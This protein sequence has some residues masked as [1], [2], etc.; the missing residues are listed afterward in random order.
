MN[1]RLIDL[2]LFFC[3][4]LFTAHYEDLN[5]Q[6]F[7]KEWKGVERVQKILTTVYGEASPYT[8][9]MKLISHLIELDQQTR[10]LITDLQ[11]LTTMIDRL[12]T[13]HKD[14]EQAF[15]LPI[16]I[17]AKLSQT[18]EKAEHHVRRA[19]PRVQQSYTH[20]DNNSQEMPPYQQHHTAPGQQPIY[21]QPQYP[22]PWQQQV[23]QQLPPTSTNT[24]LQK[25]SFKTI[26]KICGGIALSTVLFLIM[27]SAAKAGFGSN[28]EKVTKKQ[29]KLET[30][31]NAMEKVMQDNINC[32]EKNK[33]IYNEA[34]K[35]ITELQNNVQGELSKSKKKVVVSK[36]FLDE[37]ISKYIK[38]FYGD[39]SNMSIKEQYEMLSKY[40][41]TIM[42]TL[43]KTQENVEGIFDNIKNLL[44][45]A[46]SIKNE[47]KSIKKHRKI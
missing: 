41:K 34:L 4:V 33:K 13:I 15:E 28:I 47:M 25:I 1:N 45:K 32:Y 29:Q 11:M 37:M 27:R 3:T 46:D 42:D 36:E 18:L 39:G 19:S 38:D 22:T 5:A 40:E 16:L 9:Y 31:L 6:P 2:M 7:S 23:P 26:V 8:K 14:S 12:A 17:Q 24:F 21:I 30:D 43:E 20:S 44:K 10:D 35:N